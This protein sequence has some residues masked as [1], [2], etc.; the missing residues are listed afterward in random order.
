MSTE[1][2]IELVPPHHPLPWRLLLMADPSRTAIKKYIDRS[3]L[4]LAFEYDMP[5]GALA[6]LPQDE[7]QAE[8]VNLAVDPDRQG[9]GVG[10]ALI[11]TAIAD[12]R[13]RGIREIHVAT[14]NSSLEAL[15]LY[16]KTGFR[17]ARIEPDYFPAQYPEPIYEH[18]IW[19]RDRVWLVNHIDEPDQPIKPTGSGRISPVSDNP[20]F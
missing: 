10:Q 19:C 4:Y 7:T 15:A 5:I 8:I 20:G 12:A 11:R 3:L 17:L 13:T 1:L 18:G 9:Q 14:G 16:Q 2:R 6:L